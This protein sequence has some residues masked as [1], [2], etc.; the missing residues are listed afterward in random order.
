M[1]VL[2]KPEGLSEHLQA[3]IDFV[4]YYIYNSEKLTIQLLARIER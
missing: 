2:N 4:S 3:E 1:V